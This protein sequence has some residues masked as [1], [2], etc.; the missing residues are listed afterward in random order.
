[1]TKENWTGIAF[2]APAL[3][4]LF[5]FLFIPF[6]M[7]VGYSFTNY[8]ILKPDKMEFVGIKNF[9]RLTQDTVFL[10]SIVNT[11]VFVILVV[12][13]QVCLALGLALMVNRKMKGISVYRLAFFTPTVLSLVVVS[14]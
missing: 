2:I 8:N 13:L 14:R 12:P 5:I 6:F 11:F 9:I 1:M 10:K 3:I 7:T 4:L